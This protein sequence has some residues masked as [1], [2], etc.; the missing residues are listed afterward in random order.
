M[1]KIE[2][3]L[4]ILMVVPE[5]P[6]PV[7]GGLEKQS[8]ELAKKLI[9][10]GINVEVISGKIIKSQNNKEVVDGVSV[11]RLR[12]FSNKILRFSYLP[13]ALFKFIVSNKN[14]FD[15]VHAHQISWF[16]LYVIFLCKMIG[17]PVITKLPSVGDYGIPGL[18]KSLFGF[19]KIKILKMSNALICMSI[20]SL[21]E[22]KSINFPSERVF[23][24]TN[25]I[26]VD[27]EY[28]EIDKRLNNIC[29]VV[30]VGRLSK[31]KN[32]ESLLIAW[33]NIQA[34]LNFHSTLELWG[35]GPLKGQLEKKALDLNIAENVKFRGYVNDVPLRL[36]N[37][38]IFIL[39]SFAEGNSN[40]ILEAMAAGL[41]IIST[42]VGGTSMLVGEEGKRFL[43]SPN[44]LISLCSHLEL[45]INDKH[46]RIEM[47]V[48]MR[49]RV[50]KYF[51]MDK[52][53]FKYEEAYKMISL[54]GSNEI[55]TL[56]SKLFGS[57]DN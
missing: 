23:M 37:M 16:S 49:H 33:K 14:S 47:G 20:D 19:I 22:T 17:V 32:V 12:F 53:S 29:K 3:N 39:P 10:H 42:S 44:D 50:Q 11:N 1:N 45:L 43:S 38:D 57:I 56:N 24:I 6:Y 27:R 54:V 40:A 4:S 34:N 21:H 25:G 36:K 18:N 55:Y 31:E 2:E 7:T 8:H 15:I 30:F 48:A 26:N 46:L 9:M 28:I 52:V 41:P 51:S 13:F 35:D 5:Y